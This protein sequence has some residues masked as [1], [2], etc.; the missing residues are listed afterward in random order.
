MKDNLRERGKRLPTGE[1]KRSILEYLL[2][3]D[4]PVEEPYIREHLRKKYGITE[5]KGIKNHLKELDKQGCIK[6]Y[7]EEGG[8]NRWDINNINQIRN[9]H[10]SYSELKLPTYE[11]VQDIIAN[12]HAPNPQSYHR[13]RIKVG[14]CLSN[15][16]FELFLSKKTEEMHDVMKNYYLST[17]EGLITKCKYNSELTENQHYRSEYDM[18]YKLGLIGEINSLELPYPIYKYE[19]IDNMLKERIRN[20]ILD[21]T[22][23]PEQIGLLEKMELK[24]HLFDKEIESDSTPFKGF[25]YPKKDEDGIIYLEE[26]NLKY[27][28]EADIEL[29]EEVMLRTVLQT[30]AMLLRNPDQFETLWNRL[31]PPSQRNQI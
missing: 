26:N 20:E 27:H 31:V 7:P 30:I 18:Y 4:S 25:L 12:E 13:H 21:G 15:T 3:H 14:I 9:I 28:N 17:D 24:K 22:A 29:A 16:F 8:A 11:K 10:K 2:K 19:I 6:K 5:P 1:V 23:A